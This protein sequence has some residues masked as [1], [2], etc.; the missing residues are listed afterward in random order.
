LRWLNFFV[1]FWRR[2]LLYWPSVDI[3]EKHPTT[4]GLADNLAAALATRRPAWRG[5]LV[6]IGIEGVAACGSND[7]VL[8]RHGLSAQALAQRLRALL[9]TS[10][11][12][13]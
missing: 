10:A 9:P 5:Q 1:I 7:E 8:R 4:G 11:P 6:K 3:A 13:G 2:L 12:V